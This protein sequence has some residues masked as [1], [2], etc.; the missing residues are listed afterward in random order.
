MYK[1]KNE[2]KQNLSDFITNDLEISFSI[3][4]L[5][6]NTLILLWL[7]FKF[8]KIIKIYLKM[9]DPTLMY[10]NIMLFILTGCKI[11]INMK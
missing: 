10:I 4:L 9:K 8:N 1:E 7:G 6:L 3:I 2:N 5:M 11:L